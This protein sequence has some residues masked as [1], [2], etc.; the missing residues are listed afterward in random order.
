MFVLCK[1]AQVVP[2]PFTQIGTVDIF[3]PVLYACTYYAIVGL[4]RALQLTRHYIGFVYVV[5]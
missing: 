3:S 2:V 1:Y 5:V 4:I